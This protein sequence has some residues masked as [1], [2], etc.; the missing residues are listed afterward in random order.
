MGKRSK[1]KSR[2]KLDSINTNNS[3]SRFSLGGLFSGI[4]HCLLFLFL[5]ALS[6]CLLYTSASFHFT[7]DLTTPFVWRLEKLLGCKRLNYNLEYIMLPLGFFLPGGLLLTYA[8]DG[9][10]SLFACT[11]C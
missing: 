4:F 2:N 5:T 1:R 8:L 9:L 11:F 6:L 3:S 10:W 7:S